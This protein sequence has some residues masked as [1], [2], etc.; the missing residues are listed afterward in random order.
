MAYDIDYIDHPGI[1]TRDLDG[2]E[3]RYQELGFTLS[4]RSR[5]MLNDRP[6]A[7]LV[8]T[9][10]ANRCALFGESY[11]EL[12]GIVDESAPDPWR[13]KQMAAREGFRILQLGGDVEAASPRLQEAGL[14]GSGVLALE[15]DVETEEGTRTMR[16]LSVHMDPRV[17]TEGYLGVAQH[18]TP[19]YVHQPR[20]LTHPNG[21]LRVGGV[22]VVIA[23]ADH[24]AV[25]ARY[26]R[27]LDR[28]ATR[29]GVRTVLTLRAGRIEI[30][31]AS[32]AEEVLPGEPA[33]AASYLAAMNIVVADLDAARDLIEGNGVVTRPL[34]DGFL[35]SARDAYGA[36]LVFTAS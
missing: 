25:V 27:L 17:V 22:L 19:G 10:T 6:G 34:G 5:H 1:L 12:L 33:P 16:A 30:V 23:D 32:D 31:R 9:C 3:K 18:L 15:R 4:P 11:I 7:P 36:S 14:S 13:A 21:A 2:L 35:V 8:P 26:E 28:T 24:E 29:E 20:Y